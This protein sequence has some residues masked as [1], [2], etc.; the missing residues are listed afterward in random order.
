MLSAGSRRRHR[1]R[2]REAQSVSWGADH[3][4]TTHRVVCELAARQAHA[5]RS[6]GTAGGNRPWRVIGDPAA[7][8]Q[9]G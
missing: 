2:R 8:G 5:P 7:E 6:A 9:V 3:P 1:F 4:Q